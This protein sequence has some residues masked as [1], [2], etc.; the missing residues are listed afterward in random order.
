[1]RNFG[2]GL[3][4]TAFVAAPAAAQDSARNER[5]ATAMANF[6][7]GS[8]VPP[9]CSALDNTGHFKV[10]SG[11]TYLS[12]AITKGEIAEN[13][14]RQLRDA[15]RVITEA[16]TENNRGESPS[17]WYFLGRV[18]LH[19]GDVVG[20]DS[21]L[22]KAEELAPEC[23][24]EIEELRRVAFVA[25]INPGIDSMKAERNEAALQLFREAAQIYPAAPDPVYYQATL[26]YN[27]GKIDSAIPLFEETIERGGSD[28]T[29]Q[30]IVN[31]ARFYYGYALLQQNRAAE[32]VPVLETYV[33]SNPDDIDGKKLLVNAYRATGQQEKAAPYEQEIVQTAGAEGGAVTGGD[34]F[35]IG[36]ARFQ[37]KK[38]AEAADAFSKVVEAEPYNRDALFNLANAYL[39]LEDSPKLVATATRLAALD[40]MNERALQLLGEGYRM[41]KNQS[42]LIK[43]VERITPMLITVDNTSMQT[44]ANGATI[45]AT[46]TG[47]EAMTLQG[48]AVAPAPV[49]LSFE[50]LDAQGNPVATQEVT[51]PALKA[52]ET[53]TITVE[54]AGAGITAWRYSKK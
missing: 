8:Y 20:A 3:L 1:M 32:A 49:T 47:R 24:A 35:S 27:T 34:L 23:R 17:A 46:A 2:L 48:N 13:R 16:I 41:G 43:T 5:V 38:Y 44:N 52:G 19:Q 53:H 26:L 11:R 51:V 45:T 18:R 22:G 42:E 36:V 40:P 21:A 7:G 29:K 28:S 12:T 25:L 31:Q 54:G 6:T 37:E 30:Q 15:E 10:S 50:F 33:Q 39:A 14:D 9:E 4:L